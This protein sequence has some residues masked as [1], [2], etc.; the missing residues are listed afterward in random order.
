MDS[1]VADY[2]VWLE[3]SRN[4]GHASIEAYRKDL[5]G[6]SAFLE[7]EGV[8][9]PAAI[10]V[11]F[12]R[13]WLHNLHGHGFSRT[14]VARKLSSLRGY[15]DWLCRRGVLPSN[16]AALVSTP[17]RGTRLPR[18]L[19]ENEILPLVDEL[20]AL[21]D[22]SGRQ[23]AALCILLYSTGMRVSELCSLETG[24]IQPYDDTIKVT[25]KGRK[26]R[27]IPVG[28]A[29]RKAVSRWLEVRGKA[30]RNAPLFVNA[31]GTAMQPRS[32]RYRLA[33]LVI[34]MA[35]ARHISPHMLRHSFATHLLDHGADLRSVQELLGHASLSTTQI[36]THL[37][38]QRLREV[39]DA[40]HPH[41]K[42]DG[43]D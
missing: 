31:R 10:D 20:S 24:D 36:Y 41:A 14:S 35:Q 4:L 33:R 6:F 18:H 42:K 8:G 23:D 30:G 5:E 34:R 22:P 13:A 12:V 16:P 9:N 27:V 3:A 43:E 2:L 11:R 37:S 28:M 19:H 32:V 15:L 40:C 39:Y 29:A 21:E 17:K 38:K 25:G 26:E 7:S 1:G